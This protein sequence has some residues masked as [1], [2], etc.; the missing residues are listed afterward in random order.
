MDG[1]DAIAELGA[2]GR[3]LLEAAPSAAEIERRAEESGL[4]A[5]VDV[6]D[7]EVPEVVDLEFADSLEVRL[8]QLRSAFGKENEVPR[9]PYRP[10][11]VAFYLRELGRP[12]SVAIF[13]SLDDDDEERVRSIMLRRDEL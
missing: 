7:D 5:E 6:D 1:R 11:R 2:L 4:F 3:L 8:D 13:A 12:A 9:M 10:A